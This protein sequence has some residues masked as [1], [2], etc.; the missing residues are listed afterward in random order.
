MTLSSV[1]PSPWCSKSVL[2]SE[3]GPRIH[4]R[5]RILPS[6]RVGDGQGRA[7]RRAAAARARAPPPASSRRRPRA[8]WPAAPRPSGIGGPGRAPGRCP[9]ASP[10]CGRRRRPPRRSGSG[11]GSRSGAIALRQPLRVEEPVAQAQ[12]GGHEPGER[13][14]GQEGVVAEPAPAHALG[15]H[16][17]PLGAAVAGQEGHLV[18]ALQARVELLVRE[19]RELAV[20]LLGRGARH[21]RAARVPAGP[22]VRLQPLL[23]P[24]G[25]RA[26][27]PCARPRARG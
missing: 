13:L 11:A 27:A 4:S 6:I 24:R 26:A 8:R 1:L 17:A 21:H 9:S 18:D 14:G 23:H 16:V 12:D 3:P 20:E 15:E 2:R 10:R 19:A 22:E 5:G 25:R 7:S